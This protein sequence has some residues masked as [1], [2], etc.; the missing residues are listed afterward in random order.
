MNFPGLAAVSVVFAAVAMPC[1]GKVAVRPPDVSN[2]GGVAKKAQELD[3]KKKKCDALKQKQ[4]AFEEEAAIGGAVAVAWVQKGGGALVEVPAGKGVEELKD[5]K[6]FAVPA[7]PKTDLHRYVNMV[8]K[9]LAAA[10]A[11]PTLAWTFGVIEDESVN[12]YSAPGG[13]VLITKGLLQAVENEAQLAGVIAHEIGHITERHALNLYRDVK[14]NQCQAAMAASV[15]GDMVELQASFGPL[16]DS[17]VGYLELDKMTGK[18][19]AKFADSV[20]EKITSAGYAHN[21]EYAADRIALELAIAAGYNPYE[22]VKFLGKLPEGGLWAHHPKN[23][24]RQRSL[25][26][27]LNGVKPSPGSFAYADWPFKKYPAVA[28]KGE[29]AAVK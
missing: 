17:A 13:Y 23:A 24:D 7:G 19:V 3:E 5:P 16:L 21:D 11:R 26:R 15:A 18:A 29:L 10:S 22:Y 25:E 4:V 2:L 1:G 20:I 28:F 9:N 8:G 6:A 14:V 27:W 12:A